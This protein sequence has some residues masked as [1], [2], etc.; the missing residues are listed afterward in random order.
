MKQDIEIRQG[1]SMLCLDFA[2]QEE[3]DL[4]LQRFQEELM[5]ANTSVMDG[6]SN[7]LHRILELLATVKADDRL[8]KLLQHL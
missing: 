2:T 3:T 5:K 4:W 1:D 8:P 7:G 6:T